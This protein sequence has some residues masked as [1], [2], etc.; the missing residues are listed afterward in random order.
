[1][2]SDDAGRRPCLAA[3]DETSYSMDIEYKDMSPPFSAE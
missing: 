1:M 2:F 3:G